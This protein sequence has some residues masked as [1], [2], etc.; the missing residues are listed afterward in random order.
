L[1][2]NYD[3]KINPITPDNLRCRILKKSIKYSEMPKLAEIEKGVNMEE[4]RFIGI[5]GLE[6]VLNE[7]KEKQ[8]ALI[9]NYSGHGAMINDYN[10]ES[11]TVFVIDS[12]ATQKIAYTIDQILTKLADSQDENAFF[13]LLTKKE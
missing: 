6:S 10:S 1:A 8:G 11:G 5:K 3:E 12:I 4:K 9:I 7:M 13:Y 2:Q